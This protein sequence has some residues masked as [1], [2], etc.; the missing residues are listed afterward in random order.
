MADKGQK[1]AV[2]LDRDGTINI[3]K[4]YLA[5]PAKLE[6][7]PDCVPALK[8]LI[9][10]GYLLFIVTNQSGIGRGY[11]TLEDMHSVNDRLLKLL[12]PDG[13]RFE[14]IYF[15]PEHPDEDSPGRKPSP[16]FLLD[17]SAEFDVNLSDS[18]MIG[19]KLSDLQCGWNAGVRES[20]LVRTGYG[21]E[22]ET[23]TPTEIKP[24]TV[25]NTL[26]DAVKHILSAPGQ[27]PE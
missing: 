5:D 27:T 19:D 25:V 10:A 13:I 2:F 23:Q 3:E 15:A 21:E 26:S 11:Y 4:R 12:E 9:E 14:R 1:R 18:F 7:F 17:A 22:T 6:L 20:I 24:A 8:A 16:Q